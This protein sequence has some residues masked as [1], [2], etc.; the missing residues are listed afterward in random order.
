MIHNMK[1]MNILQKVLY[2]QKYQYAPR[3]EV[4]DELD[5]KQLSNTSIKKQLGET[6]CVS[7]TC[8]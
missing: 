8:D 1:L 2:I 3:L 7:S 5:F 4:L 6:H